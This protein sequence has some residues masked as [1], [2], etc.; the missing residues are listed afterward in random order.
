MKKA[1]ALIASAMLAACAGSPTATQTQEI[2]NA[3]AIDAGIR[4]AVT[5]LL[6]IPGL[7][8][9]DE[10]AAVTAARAVIDPICANPSASFQADALTAFS[11]AA[12]QVVGIEAAL[13]ARKA[14]APAAAASK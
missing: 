11:S 2:Q 6:A 9:A 8:Q 7:A 5:A 4:P 13:S 10:I 14:A 3:C 1:L 12:A